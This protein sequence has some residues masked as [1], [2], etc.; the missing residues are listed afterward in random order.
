MCV[1][2]LILGSGLLADI[3]ED[4]VEEREAWSVTVDKKASYFLIYIVSYY[5]YIYIYIL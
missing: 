3:D 4:Y 5:I 1:F 2:I